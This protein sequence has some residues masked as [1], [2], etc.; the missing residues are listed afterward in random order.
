MEKRFIEK[1]FSFTFTKSLLRTVNFAVK[2][3]G[4][5]EKCLNVS[6]GVEKRP[7]KHLISKKYYG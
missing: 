7:Q 1:A 3:T 5:L 2:A 6:L 4:K